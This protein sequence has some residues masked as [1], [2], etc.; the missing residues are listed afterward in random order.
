MGIVLKYKTFLLALLGLIWVHGSLKAD[1]LSNDCQEALRAVQN[2][3][4]SWRAK[5]ISDPFDF[6]DTQ[7]RVKVNDRLLRCINQY[8]L[9][10]AALVNALRHGDPESRMYLEKMKEDLECVRKLSKPRKGY[11]GGDFN[12]LK[13]LLDLLDRL[14]EYA[15]RDKMVFVFPE[16]DNCP[17]DVSLEPRYKGIVVE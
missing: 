9:D 7:K 2:A 13:K 17:C 6:F 3:C 14:M 16:G 8:N 12:R 10:R 15:N 5:G 1:P 11:H 4:G